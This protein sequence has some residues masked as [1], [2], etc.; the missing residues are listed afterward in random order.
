LRVSSTIESTSEGEGDGRE[1]AEKPIQQSLMSEK[2]RDLKGGG[3]SSSSAGRRSGS[4][5]KTKRLRKGKAGQR[6]KN[7]ERGVERSRKKGKKKLAAWEGH[8]RPSRRLGFEIIKEI[9]G[10]TLGKPNRRRGVVLK[11]SRKGVDEAVIKEHHTSPVVERRKNWGGGGG[12]LVKQ[13][14][15][16]LG[17]RIGVG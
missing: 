13:E 6:G 10:E 3:K 17:E 14:G 15:Q 4:R 5:R 7:A 12:K 2:R 1:N 8:C 11:A 9:V 16:G